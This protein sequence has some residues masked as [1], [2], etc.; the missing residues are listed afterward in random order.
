MWTALRRYTNYFLIGFVVA[1]VIYL[2][3]RYDADEILV[4]MII[5]AGVGIVLCLV[6]F[7]LERRFPERTDLNSPNG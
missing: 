1:F 4:G 3:I 6:I 2:F 7:I 5:G